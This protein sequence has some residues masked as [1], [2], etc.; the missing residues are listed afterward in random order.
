L[1]DGVIDLAP[2]VGR[3]HPLFVHFPI[4]ILLLAVA[5]Q[6][7]AAVAS[8][9]G[10]A[11]PFSDRA[12]AFVL[13][14]GA[15]SAVAAATTGYLLGGSGGYTGDTFDQHS[16]L[17]IGVAIVS[18]LA[19]I[20]A[21]LRLRPEASLTE[22]GEL[23]AP[24]AA[25]RAMFRRSPFWRRIYAATLIVV[26]VMLTWA[27]HLGATL[28]HGEGYLTEHAPAP[29]RAM[30]ARFGVDVGGAASAARPSADQ[31]L[32]FAALVEPVLRARC[33]QCHGAAKTEGG[34]R[35][36]GPDGLRKGGKSGPAFVAGEAVNSEIVRRIWLPASH[37]DVM[38]PRGQRPLTPAEA[39]LIRW[40]IEHGAKFDQKVIEA[41]ISPDVRPAIEEIVGRIPIDFGGP[42][43][44]KVKVA[45]ISPAALANVR[46]TGVSI[47]PLSTDT[48]FV[49][50]HCTNV[51]ETFG[52]AQ[53]AALEAIAPQILWL[54]LS[55][56]QITDA[57]LGAIEKFP[58][59]T[60]LHLDRTAITDAGLAHLTRLSH[61]EYLNLYGTKI[62]D[63]GLTPL[64]GLASL[65]AL[66]VWQTGATTQGIDR[67]KASLPQL[68]VYS[69]LKEAR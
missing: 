62:T 56:T 69:P 51:R 20:V 42:T 64:A 28:T 29:L 48:P 6:V 26:F 55:G 37:T 67:L 23:A 44:P 1:I 32:V 65:R 8:R 60:R 25:A 58:N 38:P 30:L 5:M 68:V 66:Y 10:R 40:W 53:L 27:G 21:L 31:A 59:L 2:F 35:L 52:D 61:L 45:P 4:G 16:T 36:D 34:L 43:L 15:L 46:A 50:V 41:E 12:I 3:F 63:A 9:R 33:V 24:S 7:V 11:A 17:G 39:S 14:C 57:G 19:T 54:D 22:A 49:H 47:V 18:C 13:G